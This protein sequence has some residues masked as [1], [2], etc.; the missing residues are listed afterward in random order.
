MFHKPALALIAVVSSLL[1]SRIAHADTALVCGDYLSGNYMPDELT[2]ATSRALA[3]NLRADVCY[4]V[5][6]DVCVTFDPGEGNYACGI[7][8]DPAFATQGGDQAACNGCIQ[9]NVSGEY[10]ACLFDS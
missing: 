8:S 9:A 5:C 2:S 3:S 4:G 6:A 1:V 7:G 10:L